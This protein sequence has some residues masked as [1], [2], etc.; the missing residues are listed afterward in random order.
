MNCIVEKVRM[1]NPAQVKD[2]AYQLRNEKSD[3]FCAL[4]A[5][6]AGKPNITVM[7]SDNLL[8]SKSLN[9]GQ[10]V[11]DWAQAIKGGGGGQPFFAQAGGADVSGLDAAKQLAEEYIKN[12]S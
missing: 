11:R 1:D 7:L 10:L 6:I 4:F 12:L 2:L 8:Q 3:L 9:A 5:D